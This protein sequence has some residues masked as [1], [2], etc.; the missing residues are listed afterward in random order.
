MTER[1]FWKCT[2]RKLGY[3]LDVHNA[4][5]TYDSG[6]DKELESKENMSPKER[7]ISNIRAMANLRF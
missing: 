1:E 3:L 2:I 4:V 7:E 6:E 5:N